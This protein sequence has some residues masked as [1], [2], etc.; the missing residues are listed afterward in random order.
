M[1][2]IPL[3]FVLLSTLATLV[4]VAPSIS[5]ASD[6]PIWVA[7]WSTRGWALAIAPDGTFVVAEPHTDRIERYSS[8]GAFLSSWGSEGTG[9][10]QFQN[11]LGITVAPNGDV[12]VSDWDLAR[13]QRFSSS[14]EYISQWGSFGSGP[15]QFMGPKAMAITTGGSLLITDCANSRIQE[16]TLEGSFVRFLG[17]GN[18]VGPF[19]LGIL[20]NGNL[21]VSDNR[22]QI[23]LLSSEGALIR[24]WGGSGS[25][26][27]RFENP[28]AVTTSP[29]GH[30]YVVDRLN[31]RI[32][33]F[34]E[35]GTLLTSWGGLGSG[36]GQFTFPTDIAISSSGLIYV[37]DAGNSRVQVF[38]FG[39]PVRPVT[40]TSIK[41]GAWGGEQ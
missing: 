4:V 38:D 35:A 33:V 24:T 25:D 32:Q 15:G 27:G 36:A 13:I 8:T 22:D 6:P 11:P 17:A 19:G 14:G 23:D 20:P 29:A 37:L 26:P 18:M 21:A 31:Q 40:W 5:N 30:I 16:F 28:I 39:I 7:E 12:Y 34:S 3:S 1:G 9:D 41:V 10:G 2:P